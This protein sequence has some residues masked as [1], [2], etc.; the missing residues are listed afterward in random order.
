MGRA[1]HGVDIAIIDEQGAH[2]A[3]GI[4]GEIAIRSEANMIGYWR[5]EDATAEAFTADGYLRSGDAGYID[6]DGYLYV[7]DRIKDM[8]ITGGENVYAT[9]VEAVLT[10]HPDIHEAAVI[11]MPDPQW[12]EAVKAV[13]VT[14]AGGSVDANDL[15]AWARERLAAYEVPKSIDFVDEL[16]KNAS[17]K[18]LR[19]TLRAPYWADRD[20]AI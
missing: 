13:A 18:V 12:G 20:R 10:A 19:K 15:R 14:V 16:P 4:V 8:I 6:S 17:G 2:L 7:Q 1:L 11:G 3:P 9:D 5:L